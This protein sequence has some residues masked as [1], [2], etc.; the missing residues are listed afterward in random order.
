VKFRLC[1]LAVA[2]FVVSF[3]LTMMIKRVAGSRGVIDVPNERSSHSVPTPRGGGLA[4]VVSSAA[5]LTLLAARGVIPL[6]LFVALCGGG[7]AVAS[8]GFLDD[9]GSLSPGK[10]LLVHFVAAAWAVAWVGPVSELRVGAEIVPLGATGYA[11]SVLAIVW[12]L[13]IFNFMDGIDGIAASEAVFICGAAL[14]LS[15]LSGGTGEIGAAAAAIGAAS[16]GFLA[17]NWPPARIFM[18]DVGS[19]YLGF[20]IAVLALADIARNPAALWTWLIVAGV[21]VV[22]SSVT[23]IRRKLRGERITLAHRTHAYQHLARK[24]GHAVVTASVVVIDLAWLLPCAFFSAVKPMYAFWIAVLALCP[25]AIC[26]FAV[27][28]GQPKAAEITSG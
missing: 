24:L 14:L 16:V 10:R 1:L 12:F 28:A 9:R 8:V 27:G 15:V 4:I 7:I 26:A 2:V 25:L 11:V 5:A 20:V 23:L 22:D 17:W 13:N 3:V 19:G 6:R 18:G 21:F